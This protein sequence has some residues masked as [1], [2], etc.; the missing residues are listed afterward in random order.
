MIPGSTSFSGGRALF[1]VVLAAVA[2]LSILP[3]AHWI[4]GGPEST[5]PPPLWPLYLIWSVGFLFLGGVAW[6]LARLIPW[7]G[8]AGAEAPEGEGGVLSGPWVPL[9]L[10]F[11]LPALIYALVSREVFNGRPLYLDDMTQIFQARLFADG[12]LSVPLAEDPEFF[13]SLLLVEFDGRVFSQ[14]PPGWAGLLALGVLVGLPWVVPPLVGALG[15]YGL[16]L[17]LRE[18][19]EGAGVSLLA[20]W[21]FGFSPWIVFNAASWMNHVPVLTSILLGSW[22]TVRGLRDPARWGASAAGGALLATGLLIRPLEAVAFGLPA[23]VWVLRRGWKD[24]ELRRGVA[25]FAL[26]GAA[27]TVLLLAYNWAQ[28]GSPGTFGFDVQWGPK[29]SLGF[30]EAPWGP[31]H[32]FLRGLQILN[33]Y[34]LALQQVFFEAPLPSLVPALVALFMVRKLDGVDRYLLAGSGLLLLGYLSYF[35]EGHYLGPRYL[36]PLAPLV[37]IWTVRL[38]RTVAERTGWEKAR[39]WGFLVVLILMVGGWLTG[40]QPR[41]FVYSLSYPLRRVELSALRTPMAQDA[42][43]LVPSPWSSK[44]LARLRATGLHR[45]EAQWFHDRIGFCRTELALAEIEEKGIRDAVEVSRILMPLTADSAAMV[46]DIGSGIPGDPLT[47]V[48]RSEEAALEL[49]GLRQGLENTEGG[50]LQL[51]FYAELGPTWTGEGPI[52]ARDLHEGTRRLLEAYP[53][54]EPYVLRTGRS[55]GRVREL[56]MVPLDMDS[57]QAVWNRFDTLKAEAVARW[58]GREGE[59]DPLSP[60]PRGP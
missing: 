56:R 21:V 58:R 10:T 50:Y 42:L 11:L 39:P 45:Q 6:L 17:L 5:L 18:S 27:V 33:G 37:A 16:Y 15:V 44:V 20:A 24:A 34:F 4:P 7:K 40:A 47:G 30:H 29:H 38:G 36:L 57:A 35:G 23:T 54:R 26:G 59:G 32:T 3:L 2:C 53:E 31:P 52:V 28:H 55:W 1:R 19:G 22:A 51:P 12:V 46:R 8:T 14:F 43:V 49:C 60:G 25:A 41:R 48:E 13:S 9:V